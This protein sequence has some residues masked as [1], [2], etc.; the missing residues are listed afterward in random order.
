MESLTMLNMIEEA[1]TCDEVWISENGGFIVFTELKKMSLT[2][3]VAPSLVV[4]LEDETWVK[5]MSRV[6]TACLHYLQEYAQMD[7]DAIIETEENFEGSV[8]TYQLDSLIDAIKGALQGRSVL[9]GFVRLNPV[10]RL[11]R[12]FSTFKQVASEVSKQA[13]VFFKKLIMMA[14]PSKDVLEDSKYFISL[15]KV[16]SDFPMVQMQIDDGILRAT[17]FMWVS[18][19]LGLKFVVDM[20]SG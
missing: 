8:T 3:L 18:T 6:E 4:K 15:D 9:D 13:Q 16:K 7:A 17:G 11:G 19:P 1:M 2:D 20:I 12:H 5:F 10:V 14:K